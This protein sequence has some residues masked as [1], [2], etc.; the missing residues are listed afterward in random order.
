MDLLKN[1]Y[2]YNISIDETDNKI[3]FRQ[4][5]VC[6]ILVIKEASKNKNSLEKD[7]FLNIIKN[8]LRKLN[9]IKILFNYI[10][11]CFQEIF[12]SFNAME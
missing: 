11:K 8:I 1:Y 10:Y 3:L 9:F 12:F 5:I 6:M 7:F 2:I 4:I